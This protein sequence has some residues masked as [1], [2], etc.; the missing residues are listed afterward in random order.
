R[1]C[2][3]L[4]KHRHCLVGVLHSVLVC[5]HPGRGKRLLLR[6]D[7]RLDLTIVLAERTVCES[8][9][10]HYLLGLRKERRATVDEQ[11]DSMLGFI[12]RHVGSVYGLLVEIETP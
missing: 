10:S 2:E 8:G 6:K 11:H 7:S 3:S 9:L 1:L 12:E 4:I 5:R